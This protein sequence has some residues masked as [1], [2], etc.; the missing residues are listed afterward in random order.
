MYITSSMMYSHNNM[1]RPKMKVYGSMTS[2]CQQY[3][4]HN[5]KKYE[6]TLHHAHKTQEQW[7]ICNDGLDGRQAPCAP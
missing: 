7:F 6:V 5:K 4:D 1:N 3:R 2:T